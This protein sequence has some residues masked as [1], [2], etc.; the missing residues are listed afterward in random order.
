MSLGHR[1]LAGWYHILG[2]QL[3]AGLTFCES[4]RLSQGSGLPS[5]ILDAM[6][7]TI[8]SGRSID[9]A[10][11]DATGWL[12]F[13]DRLFLSAAANAGSMPRTLHA[14]SARHGQLGAAQA[15]LLLGCLYPAAILHLGLFLFPITRMIDWEKGFAWDSGVY[16]RG[17]AIALVPLW[18]AAIV[19]MI[20]VRRENPA[21]ARLSRMIP[22]VRNYLGAQS[23]SDFCFG[24]GIF[25]EAGVPIDRAW[26][27]AARVARSPELRAAAALIAP[28]IARGEPPGPKLLETNCFPPDFIALYRSGETSGQLDQTLLRLSVQ[29]QERAQQALS[30][31]TIVYPGLMLACVAAGVGYFVISVYGGYLKML[32]GMLDP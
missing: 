20:L 4:V 16:L 30:L 25:L 3:D 10:L 21:V 17:V 22:I 24:L 31:A 26:A 19:V 8:E 11:K 5:R 32:T 9:E 1:K 13:S 12:P 27:A 7:R 14:L 2:Q 29:N 23:L 15:R 6:A 18:T 28:V